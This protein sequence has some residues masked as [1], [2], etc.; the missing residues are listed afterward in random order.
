MFETV[1]FAGKIF[2]LIHTLSE[3]VRRGDKDTKGI[4]RMKERGNE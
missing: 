2:E 1:P 3:Q 4:N